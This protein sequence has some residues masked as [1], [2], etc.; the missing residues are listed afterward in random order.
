M[1]AF[2]HERSILIPMCVSLVSLLL[3][4]VC[5][6]AALIGDGAGGHEL[7][8]RVRQP[9]RCESTVGPARATKR[10]H[11]VP[12]GHVIGRCSGEA[13][14]TSLDAAC[15]HPQA[16]TVDVRLRQTARRAHCHGQDERE[17]LVQA[18]HLAAISGKCRRQQ[19][20]SLQCRQHGFCKVIF[21]DQGNS[22]WWENRR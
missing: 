8:Y 16:L 3:A 12:G 13:E 21:N 22:Y 11:G 4:S 14:T 2:F 17:I 6:T 10:P 5:P 9:R 20:V 7:T 1:G 18:V 19:L 15:W